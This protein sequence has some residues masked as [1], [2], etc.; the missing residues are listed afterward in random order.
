[1]IPSVSL[2]VNLL[3]LGTVLGF[4]T[5][6]DGAYTGLVVKVGEEVPVDDCTELLVE[7]QVDRKS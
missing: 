4:P 3:M 6:E 1:M 5:Y 7:L 2:T